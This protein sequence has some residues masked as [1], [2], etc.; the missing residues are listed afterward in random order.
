MPNTRPKEHL[1][2]TWFKSY[3]RISSVNKSLSYLDPMWGFIQKDI[4]RTY[5]NNS[6]VKISFVIDFP[7]VWFYSKDIKWLIFSIF[8]SLQWDWERLRQSLTKH[9]TNLS[10]LIRN[11]QTKFRLF[12]KQYN[13]VLD[14]WQFLHLFLTWQRI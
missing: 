12:V 3:N 7:E 8:D 10:H 5:S 1:S 11:C 6:C 14:C 4:A 9:L 2:L 13:I